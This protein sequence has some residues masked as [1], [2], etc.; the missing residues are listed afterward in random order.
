MKRIGISA[1]SSCDLSAEL[2][3][4][5]GIAVIPQAIIMDGKTYR[6]GIELKPADIFRH[7]SEG[8]E[9]CS[10]TAINTAEYCGVFSELRKECGAL[11]H[12]TIGSGLSSCYQNAVLAANEVPGVTVVDSMNLTT[13]IGYLAVAA[14][15]M[16]AAGMELEEITAKLEE[17]KAHM[18]VSFVIDKLDYL[19]KGGRCS[20]VTAFG[21]N[22][23][24]IKPSICM[25]NGTLA[26]EKKYRGAF[27]QCVRRYIEERLDAVKDRCVPDIIFL[28]HAACSEAVLEE[29]ADLIRSRGIF[30]EILVTEAGC[31]VSSHC[32]PNTLGIIFAVKS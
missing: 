2:A 17:L 9:I 4:Q 23:L 21:A 19:K 25:K 7:V 24:N 16:A 6:D 32:G 14:A 3:E 5:Y 10:T 30:S 22:L 15:K 31:T 29:A 18:D 11:I 26:V 8:G 13:G 27:R 20:A 28:T 1:D 12:F